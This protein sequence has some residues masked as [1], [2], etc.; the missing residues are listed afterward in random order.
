MIPMRIKA[1]NFGALR[2]LNIDL[3]GLTLAS[4]GGKNGTGKSTAFTWAPLWALYG[5][6]R[7]GLNADDVIS[8]GE[9]E[10]RVSLDFQEKEQMYRVIRSR[11][12]KGRGKS[13]LEFYVQENGEWKSLSGRTVRETEDKIQ[14][15][16]GVSSEVLVS[17]SFVL[18]GKAGEFTAKTPGQRKQILADILELDVYEDLLEKAKADLSETT[19][20]KA[21]FEATISSIEE[22]LKEKERTREELAYLEKCKKQVEQKKRM[23]Q[24]LQKKKEEE[25]FLARRNR[26][27]LKEALDKSR[28][29]ESR[30]KDLEEEQQRLLARMQEAE[31]ILARKSKIL[32]DAEKA[33]ALENAIREME[34]FIQQYEEEKS[35]YKSLKKD[36]D[37]NVSELEAIGEKI[38]KVEKS[39]SDPESV[40][41][42]KRGLLDKKAFM[43]KAARDE[44]TRQKLLL[45][46]HAKD[47][48][49]QEKAYKLESAKKSL[50]KDLAHCQDQCVKLEKAHCVNIAAAL[51]NPCTFLAAASE[52]ARRIPQISTEIAQVEEEQKKLESLR[53]ELFAMDKAI[54]ALY[55]EE[56]VLTKIR[57]EMERMEAIL[58]SDAGSEAKRDLLKALS[59]QQVSLN[60]EK[61]NIESHLKEI[62][63]RGK[64]AKES[65]ARLP[66]IKASLVSLNT[67]KEERNSL[68][69]WEERCT[70]AREGLK[71]LGNEFV[72]LEMEE[73]RN[74]TVMKELQGDPSE[75]VLQKEVREI[76]V[77]VKVIEEEEQK[78]TSRIGA[79]VALL[80]RF[81]EME[82]KQEDLSREIAR[83]NEEICRF[84]LLVKAFG[85]DGIP[86]IIVENAI[87]ELE[88]ISNEI[89]G[90]M[91]RGENH[92][93]FDTTR[94]LKNREGM[95]ETLDIY[96]S[97]WEGDRPYESFSG[98][99]QLRIDLAIRFA[100]AE[101]LATRS[102]TK[103][104][105][106]VIDEGIGSQDKEHKA[107]VVDAIRNISG[108]FKKVFLVTHIEDVLESFLQQVVFS[109]DRHDPVQVHSAA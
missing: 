10:A 69:L 39:L 60:K 37:K 22:G 94:E 109:A 33:E 25:V 51:K 30:R 104:E 106:V 89:L 105:W 72:S 21:V 49:L 78:I 42:A 41:L 95:A 108:R 73:R 45:E 102:G 15:L 24:D 31:G 68:P 99:E 88:R 13:T 1:K 53:E 48:E 29:L 32:V 16:L 17:S 54:D 9:E 80:E 83:K 47:K 50:L 43:E 67:A 97:D 46:R 14:H 92:L 70:A 23:I 90:E 76:M 87:P 40:E 6:T 91:T 61:T 28:H 84:R 100:L 7:P 74:R 52:D 82:K 81:F 18:Q 5:T 86:A 62:E 38:L 71:V 96:V 12:R 57:L 36:L 4:V 79:T 58:A 107:L 77:Q 85:R 66:E 103:I 27:L 8:L 19:Q 34:P 93:R 55:V 101:F 63:I 2:D 11:S 64:K 59:C 20:K 65:L 26:S 75:D 35:A 3:S 98:G 44:K 56:E